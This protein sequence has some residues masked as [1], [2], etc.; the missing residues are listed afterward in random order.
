MFT[1]INKS[2]KIIFLIIF[3]IG[4]ILNAQDSVKFRSDTS[5]I[6]HTRQD[7]TLS[8]SAFIASKIADNVGEETKEIKK[9]VSVS[10]I[11]ITIVI[12]ILTYLTLRI[13]SGLLSVW[14]ER[15]TKHRVTIKGFIPI[16]RI[17]TWVGAISF[18][19]VAVFRPPMASLLAFSASVGVA[20]GFASQDLLKNIFGGIVIVIDKPFQIGDKIQ[21][22]GHYGEVTAI[23]LRSTRITTADDNLIT[24]PNSEVMNQAVSNANAGEENCQVVTE[25][26]LPITANIAKVKAI[27]LEAAQTSRFIYLNKPIGVLV[28]QEKLAHKI[29]LKVKVKAYVN[30]IRN[31]FA[32][33]S[34]I[35]QKL[36]QAFNEYY[37]ETGL[38]EF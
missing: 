29:I 33:M 17:L 28:F 11:L 2:A 24:I 20:V 23:G 31:E 13:T 4:G 6:V 1:Y 32:F 14:S 10:K 27:A 21:I 18:I 8:D 7:S 25:V 5:A 35:S 12:L 34:D 37:Q 9:Y 36:T 22:S 26:Y 16:I 19:V 30:D 38:N 15:N 3:L